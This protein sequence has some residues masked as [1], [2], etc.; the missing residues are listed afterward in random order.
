MISG[1]S[2]LVGGEAQQSLSS[3]AMPLFGIFGKLSYTIRKV[4]Q[5]GGFFICPFR[6][7]MDCHSANLGASPPPCPQ[8]QRGFTNIPAK[9]GK[10]QKSFK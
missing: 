2:D 8:S 9:S 7:F 3:H 5:V 4:V 6:W 1:V 10:V